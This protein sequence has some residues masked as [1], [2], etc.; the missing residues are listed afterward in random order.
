M[1]AAVLHIGGTQDGKVYVL[2]LKDDFS[3]YSWLVPNQDRR[4]I[5]NSDSFGAVVFSLWGISGL[6]IGPGVAFQKR[7]GSATPRDY[8]G[9]APRSVCEGKMVHD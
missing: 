7:R 2:I 1:R 5:C 9:K 4:R 3:S 8:T 6:G